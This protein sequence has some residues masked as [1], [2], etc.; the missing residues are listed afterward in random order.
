MTAFIARIWPIS[1]GCEWYHEEL[2]EA[3][4][5]VVP[6]V[7]LLSLLALGNLYLA[8]TI[9]FWQNAVLGV[10]VLGS[11]AA[12]C[13]E[14]FYF[15]RYKNLMLIIFQP[16]PATIILFTNYIIL[17]E[18]LDKDS[19]QLATEDDLEVQLETGKHDFDVLAAQLLLYADL[20]QIVC[21]IGL[22]GTMLDLRRAYRGQVPSVLPWVLQLAGSLRSH[23]G[24]FDEDADD[25]TTLFSNTL[26]TGRKRSGEEKRRMAEHQAAQVSAEAS[27]SRVQLPG[28]ERGRTR[29][30]S[31]AGQAPPPA[32]ASPPERPS[33][34]RRMYDMI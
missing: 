22:A 21:F 17:A 2:L 15:H 12:C 31:L 24:E 30:A 26:A 8:I 7:V 6:W 28:R 9:P 1:L 25:G 18:A 34:F 27:G 13:R 11:V 3:E 5:E 29:G 20:L 10:A 16:I 32:S 19:Y 4:R 33:T 23:G 14:I